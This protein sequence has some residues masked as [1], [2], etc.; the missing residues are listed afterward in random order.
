MDRKRGNNVATKIDV[1][2]TAEK[3]RFTFTKPTIEA[4][5]APAKGLRTY[6]DAKP[7]VRGLILLVT[8]NGV[9]TFY[10]RRRAKGEESKRMLIGRFPEI[11]VEQA[12][13]MAEKINGDVAVGIDPTAK[14][15][16]LREEPTLEA[17]F[18]MYL[19][20]PRKRGGARGKRTVIEYRKLFTSYLKPF[21]KR[22]PS[23]LTYDG[24]ET[25]T[26][27]MATKNGPYASNRLL[28]LVRA[29]Y[30][31]AIDRKKLKVENPATGIV[32]Q[33][34]VSRDRRLWDDEVRALFSVLDSDAPQ[35]LADFVYLALL[36][37]AR[38]TNLLT[39]R[40]EDILP[41]ERAVW[42]IRETKNG[43]PQNLPI[44]PEAVEILDARLG[45]RRS[46][47]VFPGEGKTGHLVHLDESWRTVLR[48]AGIKDLRIHDLRRSLGSYQVDA[49]VPLDTVGKSLNHLTTTATKI[50]ARTSMNPVRQGLMA[51]T[52][53][54]FEAAGRKRQIKQASDSP[55]ET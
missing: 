7:G 33:P 28:G 22:K 36:T 26:R 21:H 27:S 24:L 17:L 14:N 20:E 1:D 52:G 13:R 53:L 45:H 23:A 34:E 8:T 25:L 51:G 50:Y 46:E 15:A 30:N 38:R 49:G 18:E 2:G 29:L 4:L 6:H 43:R 10:V 5:P 12:R 11:S 48:K 16:A 37:G 40:W 9:K 55:T 54:M 19:E 31:F 35:D 32:A 42:R 44:M 41:L 47:Y 39:M 3:T